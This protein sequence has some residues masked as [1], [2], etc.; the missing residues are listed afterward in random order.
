MKTKNLLLVIVFA[1]GISLPGIAQ[2][3]LSNIVKNGEIRIGMSG[4]QPPFCMKSKTGKLIGYEVELAMILAENMGVELKMVEMPF[5]EL[6]KAVED[7]TVDAVM[8]GM[9]ITP[10]RNLRVLFAGPYSVSGKSILTKSKTLANVSAA[11][12]VNK[13]IF[14]IVCL[15]GSTSESFVKKY[16]DDAELI[17]VNSYDEGVALVLNDG[18]D[19]MV[20]DYPVCVVSVLRHQDAGLITLDAPLTIEPIG[21]ALPAG[22]VQFLNLIENYISTLMLTGT[23]DILESFWFEEGT[24]LNSIK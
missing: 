10:A 6:L 11:G 17:T 12:E 7:G 3:T 19:A 18:V 5:P 24:W 4:N 22:D 14:K 9:T 2:K 15:G 23:I 16:M 20:A 8:S 21:M 13:P 1:L